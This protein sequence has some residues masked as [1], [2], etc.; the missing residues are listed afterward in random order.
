MNAIGLTYILGIVFIVFGSLLIFRCVEKHQESC[1]HFLRNNSIGLILFAIASLWFL[2]KIRRLGEADFGQ[3]KN[4]LTLLFGFSFL[5]CAIYWRDFLGIRAISMLTLMISDHL[6]DICYL[7]N[8][9]VTPF[10]SLFL[11]L[12]IILSMFLGIYP[13]WAR[14][15]LPCLFR[16][17]C[18]YIKMIGWFLAIYGIGLIILAG[19]SK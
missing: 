14:D 5:G 11:Y 4:E 10:I 9:L 19:L 6:L 7:N 15:F 8:A 3:Y 12:L 18:R 17:K 1:Y 2:F 13:Y 16:K